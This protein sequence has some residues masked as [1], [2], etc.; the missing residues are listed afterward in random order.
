VSEEN[1]PTMDRDAPLTGR[2]IAVP[3][4]REVD[5]FVRMLEAEGAKTFRCPLVAILDAPNPAPIIEWLHQLAAGQFHDVVLLTGEG[6]RRL[7]G[8]AERANVWDA[9]HNGLAG[10][11]TIVRGPKPAK[12]L[13]EIGLAPTLSAEAPTTAGVIAT[14]SQLDL[15]KSCVGVQL[16]GQEP[17]DPLATF[18]AAAGAEASFVAPYLYAP[19]S[20]DD[21]VADLI[22]R[23]AR[24]EFDALALT[25]SSQ[26]DRLFEVAANLGRA[27]QLKKSLHDVVVAAVGP[28]VGA[29]LRDVGVEPTVMPE[30]TFFL[31]PLVTALAEQM[32]GGR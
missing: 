16:Y 1:Q 19:K 29:R 17:N 7:K 9:V 27:D 10:V 14:M 20:D 4:T 28:V 30:R 23:L 15:S 21:R 13:R 6:L 31:R 8:F 32:G 2:M 5:L 26:V 18:L 3:E 11:R 12:A 25:S 24:G 22:D